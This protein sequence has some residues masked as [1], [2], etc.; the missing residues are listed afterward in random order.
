M[1]RRVSLPGASELF[2]PT[3]AAEPEPAAAPD[4]ATTARPTDRPA[5]PSRGSGRVRHDEKITVYVSSDEL[6][7]LEQAR[8]TL[9]AEHGMAVD[10]GR[11][12]REAIAALL[13]DLQAQ[14][15][16]S[17]LVRRLSQP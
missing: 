10:R 1:P 3:Q 7:A 13:A 11:I 16:H 5:D 8:L 12:V 17:E 15:G 9:R 2:R 4:P 6:V 14:G